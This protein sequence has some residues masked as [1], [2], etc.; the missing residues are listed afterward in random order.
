MN[1]LIQQ[2]VADYNAD[3]AT[4]HDIQD[5]VEARVMSQDHKGMVTDPSTIFDR[6]TKVNSIL[7]KIENQ[8]KEVG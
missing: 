2:L 3:R 1:N 5:V 4:W 7:S 6:M 8:I